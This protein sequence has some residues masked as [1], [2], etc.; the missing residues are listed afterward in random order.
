M[1]G[2]GATQKTHGYED[3]KGISLAS[4]NF[5]LN[6]ESRLKICILP[7]ECIYEFHMIRGI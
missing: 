7:T 1:G 4:F 5:L 6:K 3:S 2:G